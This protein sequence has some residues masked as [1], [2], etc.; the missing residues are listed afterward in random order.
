MLPC[1]IALCGCARTGEAHLH[2]RDALAV[3]V[4]SVIGQPLDQQ[5]AQ[6]QACAVPMLGRSQRPSQKRGSRSHPLSPRTRTGHRHDHP[7]RRGERRS[8][9]P[10]SQPVEY[11]PSVLLK[12]PNGQETVPPCLAPRV[13]RPEA[14]ADKAAA[15]WNLDRWRQACHGSHTREPPP[16]TKDQRRATKL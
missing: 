4:R 5:D 12:R 9:T 13:P 11:P 1:E 8:H 15:E 7:D 2:H 16:T 14:H 3:A 10:Q 6:P